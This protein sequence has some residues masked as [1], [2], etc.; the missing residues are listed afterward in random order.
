M[1]RQYTDT[2]LRRWDTRFL[3]YKDRNHASEHI[4]YC[5]WRSWEQRTKIVFEWMPKCLPCRPPSHLGKLPCKRNMYQRLC[6]ELKC[7]SRNNCITLSYPAPEIDKIDSQHL[8]TLNL[9]I[10]L[11]KS[12][13]ASSSTAY[14]KIQCKEWSSQ[15]GGC[16]AIS[17]SEQLVLEV[18]ADGCQ[19]R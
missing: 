1:M 4:T 19:H 16:C 12:I 9:C 13:L 7:K 14:L 6:D 2:S 10:M 15:I 5:R 18:A 17:L 8:T 3:L 11:L